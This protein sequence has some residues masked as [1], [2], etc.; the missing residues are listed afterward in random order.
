MLKGG[1]CRGELSIEEVPEALRQRFMRV[2]RFRRIDVDKREARR[3]LYD[4]V[5][6]N[7][8]ETYIELSGL[9]FS[10]RGESVFYQM[11]RWMLLHHDAEPLMPRGDDGRPRMHYESSMRPTDKFGKERR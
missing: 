5:L 3:P 11:Q 8:T 9:E 2:A 7:V 1:S 4:P 6:V 10:Q